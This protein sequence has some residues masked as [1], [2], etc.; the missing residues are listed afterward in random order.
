MNISEQH[1]TDTTDYLIL[2]EVI[3]NS[4]I[5]NNALARKINLSQPATHA[6]LK[7]LKESGVIKG[8]TADLDYEKLGFELTCFFQVQLKSH[9]EKDIASFEIEI[10]NMPEILECHYLTG[11]FDYLIKGAFQGRSE[12]ER[13]MRS[14]LSTLP[15][16]GQIITSLSLSQID[17]AG[18]LFPSLSSL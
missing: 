5:S 4:R 3:Q 10:A 13:F 17:V 12:L 15:Q 18:N 2:R 9:L 16:V 8:F 6:R 14:S 1:K 11:E 7:R